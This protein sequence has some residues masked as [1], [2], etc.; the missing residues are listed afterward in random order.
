M[1]NINQ[2]KACLTTL[3]G[4]PLSNWLDYKN[5]IMATEIFLEEDDATEIVKDVIKRVLKYEN[6]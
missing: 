6:I 2:V 1:N 4:I 5:A 3:K